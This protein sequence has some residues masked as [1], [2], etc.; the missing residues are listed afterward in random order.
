MN[1]RLPLL[2]FDLAASLVLAVAGSAVPESLKQS[3]P[4][5]PPGQ[6]ESAPAAAPG[7]FELRGLI[8][9][10]GVRRFSV[11]DNT[12]GRGVWLGLN[13]TDHGIRATAFD[14]A[15]E[16]LTIETDGQP[17]RLVMKKSQIVTMVTP[18]VPVTISG[19]TPPP[20]APAVGAGPPSEQEIQERRNRIVEELRRRRALRQAAQQPGAAPATQ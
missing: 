18:V 1:A 12:T 16:A 8:S 10:G 4:F 7:R 19:S 6:A 2:L 17:Q 11:F 9:L 20:G 14:A 3:S 15:A 5:A 13:D